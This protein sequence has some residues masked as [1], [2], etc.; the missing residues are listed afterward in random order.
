MKIFGGKTGGWLVVASA[1]ALTATMVYGSRA[2]SITANLVSTCNNCDTNVALAGSPGDYS[3]LPDVFGAYPNSNGVSSQVLTNNSVYNL[4]T[5]A[6]LVNGLVANSTRTVKI[7]FYS[8]VEGTVANDELPACW[9]GNHDQDQAV[10]WNIYS[11]KVGFSQMTVGVSYS[12][13]ARMDFNVRNAQCDQQIF[14]YYLKWYNGCIV[15]TN[16][17]T[18]VATSDSCG[19]QINYGTA[20]LYGQGG[21]NGQTAYSGDWRVPYQVVL[22]TP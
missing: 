16:P 10:N 2:V 19:V 8:P 18:W 1:L 22:T 15:R 21:K 14:R 13:F 17:T 6:T 4:T 7:H 5:T 3:L 9:G 12:G 20:G 11:S